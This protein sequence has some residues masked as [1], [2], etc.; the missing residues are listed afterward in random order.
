LFS[1]FKTIL[2]QGAGKNGSSIAVGCHNSM[3]IPFISVCNTRIPYF[4]EQAFCPRLYRLR[5]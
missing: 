3:H 5:W 1:E 4:R 2:Y